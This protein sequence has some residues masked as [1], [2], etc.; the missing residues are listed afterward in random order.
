MQLATSHS[1]KRLK[2]YQ[3][4]YALCI[5]V[6]SFLIVYHVFATA[7]NPG[8]NFSD[9]GGGVA[10]GDI[11]YGS[12]TDTLSALAKNT[13]STRYLSNTGT[14]NNPAWAQVDVDTGITGTV[15]PANGGT[16]L[17]TSASTGVPSISSGTW[18]VNSLLPLSLGGTNANITASNGGIF[19]STA[20]AAALLS[21]TAT[22]NKILYSGSS[23][24]PSWSTP[25]FPVTASATSG[26]VIKSDG[27][28]WIASTETYATP[29]TSGNVMTSNG[30]NWTSVAQPSI[31]TTQTR[32]FNATGATTAKSVASLTAFNIGMFSIPE[33]ITVN[34]MSFT[35]TAVTTAGTMK[36]CVYNTSG[37]KL[38]DVTTAT[39]AAGTVSTT[40]SPAVTLPAG[41]Y[42]IAHGCATTCSDTTSYFTST[43]VASM[44]GAS[45]PSGKLKYEGTGTMTSGTCNSSLPTI[46]GAASSTIAARLDN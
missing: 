29:G 17:D 45:V 46:T 13:S 38:I 35:V 25:T 1:I 14:S 33:Q 20:S 9:V 11:L 6:I 39:I 28:N 22:A 23:A 12:A 31:I 4:G 37:T 34:Q 41:N 36:L 19:Y 24:A 18:S 42:Y 26:T 32:S 2:P 27:T 44:N 40:V 43:A 7:P 16:N 3:I 5:L 8:H 15:G 21:G 10:Q 30:T